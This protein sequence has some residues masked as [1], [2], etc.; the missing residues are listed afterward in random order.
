MTIRRLIDE[1]ELGIASVLL[2]VCLSLGLL[3]G[4]DLKWQREFPNREF[5][6][7]TDH[8]PPFQIVPPPGINNKALNRAA[9]RA[10]AALARGER[11]SMRLRSI[12]PS[13]FG[14]S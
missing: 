5:V 4:F 13:I 6:V 7:A 14:L 12:R 3:I 2:G 1:H 11:R 8:S 10:S 9:E